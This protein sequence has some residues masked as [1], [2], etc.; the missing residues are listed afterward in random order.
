MILFRFFWAVWYSSVFFTIAYCVIT[1]NWLLLLA[2]I[3]WGRIVDTVGMS[4][5]LHRYFSHRSFKTG[6]FR[7]K[8][9][10]WFSVLTGQGGP[11][12]WVSTH[13]HHHK[14]SDTEL[15]LHSPNNYI[16]DPFIWPLKSMN[17][18]V[19]KQLD[20]R[21][22]D[23]ENDRL[24]QFINQKYFLIWAILIA[25]SYFISWEFCVFFVLGGAGW[26][27]IF[28]GIFNTVSHMNFLG[29]YRNFETNDNTT[30]SRWIHYFLGDGL[31]NNH[32]HMSGKYNQAFN[33]GEF[34]PAGW[35]CDKF[36]ATK[37]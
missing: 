30:N 3:I 36:F 37:K 25:I 9:L 5:A 29:S 2:S 34:D 22:K 17:Y 32:H 27:L 14:H 20:L 1:H 31:H 11:L 8:F 12:L 21:V 35:I 16:L 33:K 26:S 15:D 13:R 4:I 19:V 7:H 18:F 28:S 10:S 24:L 6:P 23:L